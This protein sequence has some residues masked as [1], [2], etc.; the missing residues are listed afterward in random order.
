MPRLDWQMWFAA[1]G[2]YQR[3]PWLM[4]MMR[5]LTEGSPDV[6]ALLDGNPF[7]EEPPRFVRAVR[8]RY[9]FTNLAERRETGNWW[10]REWE[11]LYAPVVR[12]E[13]PGGS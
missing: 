12:A 1:L 10:A 2:S 9:R 5:K 7:P 13:I 4:R 3:N 8:W 6:L 11:G